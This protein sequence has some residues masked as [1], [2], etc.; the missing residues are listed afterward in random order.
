MLP[1]GECVIVSLSYVSELSTKVPRALEMG[2]KKVML[3][4][5]LLETLLQIKNVDDNLTILKYVE[6]T[7]IDS[8][9]W[10]YFRITVPL[11]FHILLS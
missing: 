5:N 11:N 1:M 10:F 3:F 6:F 7:L 2:Q 8:K 4:F 9:R